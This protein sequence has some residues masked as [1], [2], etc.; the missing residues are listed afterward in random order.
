VRAR[1]E[2]EEFPLLGE[3]RVAEHWCGDIILLM[4]PMLFG[5]APGNAGLTVLVEMWTARGARMA[6]KPSGPSATAAR[7][8]S[9]GSEVTTHLAGGKIGEPGGSVRACHRRCSPRVAVIDEHL[10][11]V[12]DKI[13]GESVPHM[14]ETNHTDT[15]GDEFGGHEHPR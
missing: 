4:V 5:K 10:V 11:T 8:S 9:S 3:V 2:D 15:S 1:G 6:A 12:S 7:A 13:D 14:A